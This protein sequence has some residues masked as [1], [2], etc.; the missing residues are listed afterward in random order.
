[1]SKLG[2]T[3][4]SIAKTCHEANRILC[5]SIGDDSQPAWEDA[6]DWQKN[7]ARAGVRF[8]MGGDRSPSESHESWYKQKK[9]EGWK[10]GKKKDPEKKTH[11]CMVEYDKLPPE[12]RVKDF[13]F[14]NIVDAYKTLGDSAV[15]LD[16]E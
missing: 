8:H 1:M 16:S 7:S 11:P 4:E 2:I 13:I 14:K 3:I 5:Q 10:Y 12:Q 6:P 9:E 15:F